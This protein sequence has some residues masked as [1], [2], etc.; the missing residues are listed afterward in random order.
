[1][2]QS[3][4]FSLLLEHVLVRCQHPAVPTDAMFCNTHQPADMSRCVAR[5]ARQHV[6]HTRTASGT[7][8]QLSFL[9][10]VEGLKWEKK[11]GKECLTQ[12]KRGC[13]RGRLGGPPQWMSWW[14]GWVVD[15]AEK[16]GLRKDAVRCQDEMNGGTGD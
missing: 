2:T 12:R 11:R 5:Q 15:I 6:F 1:M 16:A 8:P 4:T 3:H 10:L 9:L 13:A 7:S 14:R